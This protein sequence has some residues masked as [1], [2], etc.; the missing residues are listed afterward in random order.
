MHLDFQIKK[1]EK[2]SI[3]GPNG[4]GKST[5]LNLISGF[6]HPSGGNIFID[7]SNHTC[8]PPSFRPISIIFQ[9]NN[10]FSHLTVFQNISLGVSYKLRLSE[11]KRKMIDEIIELTELN[12]CRNKFPT[13]IS[14]GQK[15]LVAL[16]RCLIRKQP[17][18][19][20]DEPFSSID[21][22]SKEKILNILNQVCCE[23]K[24]TLLTVLHDFK[25]ATRVSDRFIVLKK[26]FVV[27]DGSVAQENHLLWKHLDPFRQR[28]F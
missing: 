9:G 18:M 21:A 4:S 26:G 15:Q 20:L 7:G 19:L 14:G 16:A 28:I 3:L 1:G 6:Y 11:E 13:Q 12:G 27:Y 8:T 10:L 24:I 5:L 2:V 17:I 23:E 25:D 22:I